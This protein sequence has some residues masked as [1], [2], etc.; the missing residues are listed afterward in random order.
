M[1]EHLKHSFYFSFMLCFFL[2]FYN[3]YSSLAS[4]QGLQHLDLHGCAIVQGAL[5]LDMCQRMKEQ[6]FL[7]GE[8]NPQNVE[9]LRLDMFQHLSR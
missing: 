1:F 9:M 7:F 8:V 5:S 2:W 4:F 3:W 6:Q